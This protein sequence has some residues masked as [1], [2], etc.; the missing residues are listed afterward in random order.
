MQSPQSSNSVR[1]GG[2]QAGRQQG[3]TSLSVKAFPS[4]AQGQ[5]LTL[6]CGRGMVP[7]VSEGGA[8]IP[9][10]QPLAVLP[11]MQPIEGVGGSSL[12][13]L[14]SSSPR[15]AK[16]THREHEQF[17]PRFV[18]IVVGNCRQ[19]PSEDLAPAVPGGNRDVTECGRSGPLNG[20]QGRELQKVRVHRLS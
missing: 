1:S 12:S 3:S 7:A 8:G 9:Q 19:G 4:Q 16:H 20:S 13:V 2:A 17:P 6:L 5:G 18:I 10:G 15:C 11:P 14:S